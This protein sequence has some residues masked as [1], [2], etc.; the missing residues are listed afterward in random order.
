MAETGHRCDAAPEDRARGSWLAYEGE[1]FRVGA[2]HVSGVARADGWSVRAHSGL[3]ERL[4]ARL[5]SDLPAT[6]PVATEAERLRRASPLQI[7]RVL[8]HEA[9]GAG[10]H[11]IGVLSFEAAHL[12]E[13]LPAPAAPFLEFLLCDCEV[14]RIAW[15]TPQPSSVSAG[16]APPSELVDDTSE[17]FADGFERVRE[18]L[19]AGDAYELVLSRRWT[20]RTDGGRMRDFLARTMDPRRAPYRFVLDFPLTCV[21]GASPELLVRVD[22][23]HVTTRPIS[24]S[25]RRDGTG[26]PLTDAERATF[27]ELLRSEKEKSELDMLIDLARHDLHRVCDGVRIEAY[28]SALVLETVVH[29]EATVKGTLKPGHDALDA[30]F[31]CL[32]AGTL[33]GA[34]KKKAMEIIARL[35]GEPRRYYGGTLLHVLPTGDLRG[36]ILIRTGFLAGDRLTL[37]AGATLLLDSDRDYEFWE[38]GAKARSLLDE[39]GHGDLCFGGGEPPAIVAGHPVE[40]PRDAWLE[41]FPRASGAV[42]PRLLLVDNE[43]SFTW[44]LVALFRGLGCELSVVRSNLRVDD[45]GAFDG[46]VLSPGPSSP[47]DAGWLLD[48]VRRAAG[49]VPVFGVCLGMQA[50]VEGLGGQLGRMIRPLHGKQ[51]PVRFAAPSRFFEGLD[52]GFLAARYHSLHGVR[53]PASLALTAVDDDGVALAVEGPATWPPFVGVQF[54]PESFL[55]GAPGVRLAANWLA[56]LRGA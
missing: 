54:H 48:Y 46:V 23:E 28:R 2:V 33:V 3:G 50:M 47:S 14:D 1:L 36:T 7:V 15:P 37:Q 8:A 38:C 25:M 35:E 52:D 20:F 11:L 40:R 41:A 53:L 51:R 12:H 6:E 44:N 32:N 31:S 55:T 16:D 34:P 4:V 17:R 19:R 10:L 27:E 22:G 9:R 39:I 24:G 29:T 21:V 30:L 43:D 56:S 13:D 45:L 18:H 5:P 49:A 26:G 42:G